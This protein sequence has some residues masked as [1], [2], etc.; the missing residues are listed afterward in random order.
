MPLDIGIPELILI[1]VVLL[2]VF[3]PGKLPELAR[4]L[5]SMVRDLRRTVDDLTRDFT[6]ETDGHAPTPSP[7]RKMC[8]RCNSPNALEHAFCSR[9]G[10][11]LS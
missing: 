1:F 5:G 3:G 7:A 11:S 2:M 8:P 4:G 6:A 10:A 9:C